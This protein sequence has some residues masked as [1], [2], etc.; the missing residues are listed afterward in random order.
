MSLHSKLLMAIPVHPRMSI[1]MLHSLIASSSMLI[2]FA[3]VSQDS[4]P[5]TVHDGDACEASPTRST[6]EAPLI[7]IAL[8]NAASF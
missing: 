1:E 6:E 7:S 8:G 2:A 4:M 3:S 5:G